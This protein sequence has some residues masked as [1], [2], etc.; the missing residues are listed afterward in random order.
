M[1][2][3]LKLSLE[4]TKKQSKLFFHIIWTCTIR[5]EIINDIA[6]GKSRIVVKFELYEGKDQ[7]QEKE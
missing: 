5:T 1:K 7:M 6:D 3:W 2:V 4:Y